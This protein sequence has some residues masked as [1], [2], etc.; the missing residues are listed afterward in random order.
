MAFVM[1]RAMTSL[2]LGTGAGIIPGQGGL[3]GL[4]GAVGGVIWQANNPTSEI[5]DGLVDGGSALAGRSI[6]GFGG[7]LAI[8]VLLGGGIAIGLA[9]AHSGV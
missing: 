2:A 9:I 7:P 5:A 4:G 8:I 6:Q 1:N 3:I